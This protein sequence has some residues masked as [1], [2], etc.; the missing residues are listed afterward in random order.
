MAWKIGADWERDAQDVV[1]KHVFHT[2]EIT[3]TGA[4]VSVK[5]NDTADVQV[6]VL[7]TGQIHHMQDDTNAEVFIIGGGS[8]TDLKMAVVTGPRD[9]HYKSAKGESWGQDPMDPQAR[10]GYTPNGVRL[11]AQN[12]TIAEYLTGMFEIDVKN[13]VIYF[14]CP[15]IFKIPPTVGDPPPYKK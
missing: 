7:V 9:K 1:E 6:P 2:L 12:K 14:R 5:G 8:D 15:V 11:A 4:Q 13:N 3:D 10:L